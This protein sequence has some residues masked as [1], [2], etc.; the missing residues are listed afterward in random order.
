M[1]RMYFPGCAVPAIPARCG[2]VGTEA[3]PSAFPLHAASI[4]VAQ[5]SSIAR[6]LFDMATTIRYRKAYG[7]C[8][9]PA[10]G[11]S[12]GAAIP[13]NSTTPSPPGFVASGVFCQLSATQTF[14]DAST[15]M[16]LRRIS[17]ELV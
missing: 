3:I 11:V 5:K 17:R 6:R 13:I 1:C 7:C 8:G 9:G 16:P 12:T 10:I 2:I 14:P 4:V 15:T